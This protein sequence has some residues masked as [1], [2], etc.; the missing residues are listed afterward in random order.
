MF[1]DYAAFA[2]ACRRAAGGARDAAGARDALADVV[3]RASCDSVAR[4]QPTPRALAMEWVP[5]YLDAFG[6]DA[7]KAL[8]R[9]TRA[10]TERID[11]LRRQLAE[12]TKR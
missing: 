12:A 9:A 5:A 2:G 8:R 6:G 7:P 3:W 10:K 11:A 4:R 1:E